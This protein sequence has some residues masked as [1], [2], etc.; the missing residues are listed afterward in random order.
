MGE[1]VRRQGV[2]KETNKERNKQ[3]IKNMHSSMKL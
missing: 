2:I 3:T 1:T